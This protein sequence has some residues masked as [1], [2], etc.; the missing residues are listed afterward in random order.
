MYM[1]EKYE[2]S[3]TKNHEFNNNVIFGGVPCKGYI[4][5]LFSY[6]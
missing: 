2:S 1:K 4:L 6:F 3:I 5:S